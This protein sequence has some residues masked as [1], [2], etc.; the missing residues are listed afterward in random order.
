MKKIIKNTK[1]FVVFFLIQLLIL[2]NMISFAAENDLKDKDIKSALEIELTTDEGVASHLIDVNI[3]DGIVTLSGSVDSILSKERAVK[4]ARSIKGIR[5]VVDRIEVKPVEQ[6]DNQ[7]RKNVEDAL[8]NDPATDSYEIKVKVNDG[9]VTLSGN[10]DSYAEKDLCEQVAKG[11]KGIKEIDNNIY[12]DYELERPDYEIKEDVEKLL[13]SDIRVDDGLVEV[14]VVDGKVNLSGTVGSSEEKNQAKSNAWVSGVNSVDASQLN[15]EWWARD[16]MIRQ[17]LYADLSDEKVEQAVKD[18]FVYD[19]RVWS[20]NIDVDASNGSVTLMGTVDNLKAKKAAEKNAE[21]T[22]G[23]WRVKNRLKVRPE[24]EWKDSEIA[25]NV[26]ESLL[27]DPYID[28]YDL[29]VLSYN[30]KIHMYGVVDTFFE[31]NRAEDIA[32]RTK[33]VVD[34]QNSIQVDFVTDWRT[35]TWKQDWEIVEDIN[36]EMFWS[37]FVDSDDINVAVDDGVATLTGTVATWSERQSATEN[38]LEGGAFRVINKL[39]VDKGSGYWPF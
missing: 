14:E 17:D 27:M 7:I 26:R 32:S 19:P 36:S 38:A 13:E 29:T 2:S 28:R 35:Q 22:L 8:F 31:K 4:V 1:F 9:M 39:K 30:G 33:G 10:V 34:V 5:S 11:V 6:S 20:F 21:N 37:P 16:E 3:T 25:E 23:V 15:I 18:S 12:V 24:D